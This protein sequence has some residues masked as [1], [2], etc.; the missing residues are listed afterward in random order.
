MDLSSHAIDDF[1]NKS[2]L[3]LSAANVDFADTRMAT[4]LIQM[5]HW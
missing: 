2:P 4:D 5:R 3:L 1:E